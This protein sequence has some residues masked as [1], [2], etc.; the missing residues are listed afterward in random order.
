MS[1]CVKCPTADIHEHRMGKDVI[2]IF[3][4]NGWS[5]DIYI[6]K[7]D[8]YKLA[9]GYKREHCDHDMFVAATGLVFD[10]CK[11]SH[12]IILDVDHGMT[13]KQMPEMPKS[14]MVPERIKDE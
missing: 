4:K 3:I 9:A 5:E 10:P 1:K 7:E 2:R 11:L 13:K 6:T 8:L 12:Y 14:A